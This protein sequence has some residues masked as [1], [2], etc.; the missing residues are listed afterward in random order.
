MIMKNNMYG[1]GNNMDEKT[2]IYESENKKNGNAVTYTLTHS[3]SLY[4]LSISI[5]QCHNF[6]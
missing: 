3:Q 1:C 2:M 6:L 5:Q 4:F